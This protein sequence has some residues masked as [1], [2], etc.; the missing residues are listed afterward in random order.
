MEHQQVG[1]R[2]RRCF[3]RQPVTRRH[4]KGLF[5][6][7]RSRI[8]ITLCQNRGGLRCEAVGFGHRSL[9]RR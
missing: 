7:T 8:S 6:Q 4:R 2:Q 9:G 5:G 1:V 3:E